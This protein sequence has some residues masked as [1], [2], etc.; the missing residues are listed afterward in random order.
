MPLN[1]SATVY[2]GAGG[3]G[4]KASVSTP[5]GLR[6]MM[7]RNILDVAPESR[8]SSL[9]TQSEP[10]TASPGRADPPDDHKSTL[11]GLNDRLSSYLA[12]V[13]E[14]TEENADLRDK[15]ED[16]KAKRK[17]PKGRDWVETQ[18]PLEDLEKRVSLQTFLFLFSADISTVYDILNSYRSK[19]SPKTMRSSCSVLTTPNWPM[20]T[21]RTSECPA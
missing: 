5:E 21:S 9:V 4:A 13:R 12:K 6:N 3:R 11:R 14:L 18:K 20:R 19:N 15:I 1:T 10:R 7:Q 8:S 16:I 17:D 2:G